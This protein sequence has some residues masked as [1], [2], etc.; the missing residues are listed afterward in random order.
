M[1][2]PH[3]LM[4]AVLLAAGSVRAA[5]D[6]V[7]P[8][9]GKQPRT[10]IH[11]DPL[12]PGALVR[13]GTLRW[14][15]GSQV[16]SLVYTPDGKTLAAGA[17]DGVHLFDAASGKLRKRFRPP[18]LFVDRVAL[19]PD[20]KRLACSCSGRFGAADKDL[21]QV[22]ELPDERKTIETDAKD[23]L[24]FGWSA[25]GQPL[26]VFRRD[27][28]LLLRELAGGQEKRLDYAKLVNSAR[29]MPEW[30]WAYS[31][32]GKAL[33]APGEGGVIHVWDAGTGKKRCAL[34]AKGDF[35]YSPTLSPDGRTLAARSGKG[36]RLWDI[37][38][39]PLHIVAAAQENI[40][41]LT[42]SPDGK[43][44]AVV[45]CWEEAHFWDVATG[46]EIG[47]TD[48]K[49]TFAEGAVVFSPDGKTLATVEIYSGTVHLWDVA[50]GKLRHALNGHARWP[51]GAAF[52]PDGRRLATGSSDGTIFLWDPATGRQLTQVRRPR[53]WALGY[54]FSAD[55]QSLYSFWDR[56][57]VYCSSAATG[58]ELYVL[59]IEDPDH[60]DTYQSG[61]GLDLSQDRKTLVTF[62][63]YYAKKR[64]ADAPP[65]LFLTGWDTATR[66][67]LFRRSRPRSGLGLAVSADLRLLAV[68]QQGG[69]DFSPDSPATGPLRLEDLA[70]GQH[71]LNLPALRGQNWPLAFSP[72]GRLLV[73]NHHGPGPDGGPPEKFIMTLRLWEVATGTEALALPSQANRR[74]T[75]S[76]DGRLLALSAPGQEIVLWDLRRGK[77]RQRLKGLG[78]DVTGLAFSPDGRRLVS[79]LSDTTSLIWEVAPPPK[80]GKAGAL[81]AK[82]AA[83]AWA[84]LGG[85]ARQAFAARGV[86]ADSPGRALPLL[87]QRLAPAQPADARRLRRLI[88]ELSSKR[89]AVRDAARRGLEEIG[90]VAAGALRRALAEK[91]SLEARR[92]I[93]DLLQKL[94]G[95]VTKPEALRALRAVAVL[96]D[97]ASP[98]SR[99]ILRTL[100]GGDPEA[101]LTREARASLERLALHRPAQP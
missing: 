32:R 4:L 101:R 31:A 51:L 28:G 55:G 40:G 83:R 44:L 18:N 30:V 34:E 65:D 12:P 76:P 2:A 80:A 46:K 90:D 38:G 82:G 88:D 74:L 62:S 21:L 54:A 78:A 94:R 47:R 75:F 41:A 71:L 93:E 85:D 25:K 3:V 95:P 60:P 33:A 29:Q 1:R 68:S 19:S 91:P 6:P 43:T 9:K 61:L 57:K 66:K 84:D 56:D 96:E 64:G 22:W 24:W 15:A 52:S 98:E 72:D 58:K 70:T 35:L 86:L 48:G 36:V 69:V 17:Y 50:T 79:G 37:S 11:G 63:S 39:K 26:A 97:I 42:F 53:D 59:K 16:H 13:L 77:E 8:D 99:Q 45:S 10:D 5:T 89:F 92:R 81:D 73:S 14:R 23:L 20:G 49:R 100:A 7:P 27:G 67:Q 87:K